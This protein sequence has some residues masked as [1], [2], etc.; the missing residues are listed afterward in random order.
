MLLFSFQ[1]RA[2]ALY[3]WLGALT[4]T[5]ML[6]LAVGATLAALAAGASV[7]RINTDQARRLVLGQPAG[8]ADR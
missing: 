7:P 4:A 1:T 3:G 6:G 8:G 5:F 2:G